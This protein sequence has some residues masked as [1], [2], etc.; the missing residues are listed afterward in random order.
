MRVAATYPLEFISVFYVLKEVLLYGPEN[1]LGKSD[2]PPS[3]IARP[4]RV[5]DHRTA[6]QHGQGG[7]TTWSLT[8]GGVGRDCR[9][10]ARSRRAAARSQPAGGR[11]DD[12]RS[13]VVDAE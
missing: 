12:L 8:V 6:R 3:Q 13:C 7:D 10:R 4:A 1:R 2:W 11:G 9:A 5:R